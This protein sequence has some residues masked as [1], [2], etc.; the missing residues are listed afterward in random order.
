MLG[1]MMGN[2]AST[3]R[4]RHRGRILRRHVIGVV[5]RLAQNISLIYA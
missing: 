5:R 4:K 3:W 2:A 1:L